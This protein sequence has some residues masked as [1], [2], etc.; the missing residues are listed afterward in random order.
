M[1]DLK[2]KHIIISGLVSAK[3]DLNE[4]LSPLRAKI[5][6]MGGL[7]VGELIQRRG[8][9]RSKKPGGAKNMDNTLSP[10]TYINSGK[11]KELKALAEK[12]KCDII[13][14]INRLTESQKENLKEL[15]CVDIEA[16]TKINA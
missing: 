8:V 1:I 5:I 10:K 16:I 6:N 12:Q 7:I 2:E 15:T 3:L 11:V 14:F 4:F 9:S 13:I